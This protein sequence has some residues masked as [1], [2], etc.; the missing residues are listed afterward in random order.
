VKRFL[1][2]AV[3]ALVIISSGLGG[4][5][6]APDSPYKVLKKFELGGEGGWDYLTIDPEA[7]RL[8]IARG[9]H[10]M[11]MDLDKG[12]VVGDLANTP[13]VH[14]V[15]LVPKLKRG[16]TSNG[17]DSTVTMFDTATLKEIS[18]VEVGKGPDFIAYDPASN[19]VFTF[20]ATSKDA[21][22]I[23]ADSGKV[24]GTVTLGGRPEAAVADDKGMVYVNILG[25]NEVIAIDAKKLLVK[26]RWPIAPGTDPVGLGMDRGKRRLFCSCRNDKMVILDADSGKV[27]DSVAIGKGTDACVFDVD[28]HLAFSSNKD[29]TLTVVGEQPGSDG[30]YRVVDNVMTQ[31]GA[32]TMALDPKTHNI[33]LATA[34][35][36]DAGKKTVPVANTFTILV[37]GN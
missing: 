24:V 4:Q 15:A 23:A 12:T 21:T 26:S 36:K 5:A 3:P 29:G 7:R 6:Q 19:Q 8:Y 1:I 10:V 9:S 30:K 33:Y 14:G 34:Q 27:L 13:G 18:R 37:V 11:V 25:A 22:A 16:F 20:N 28:K 2:W 32:K 35:F 31:V 17:G